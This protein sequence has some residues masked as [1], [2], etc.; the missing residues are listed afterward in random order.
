MY[1]I[2]CIKLHIFTIR[3]HEVLLS[4][5]IRYSS[6]ILIIFGFILMIIGSFNLSNADKNPERLNDQ[7]P[8]GVCCVAFPEPIIWLNPLPIVWGDPEGTQ[9]AAAPEGLNVDPGPIQAIDPLEPEAL[10][11]NYDDS[12]NR[13]AAGNLLMFIE[14]SFGALIMIASGIGAIIAGA[15]GAYKAAISL[16]FVAVGSFILRALVSLFFGTE[17]DAYR[18]GGIEFV[19]GGL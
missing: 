3:L 11:A 6:G 8:E 19:G 10:D 13:F 1:R 15:F 4:S 5:I 2:N 17:Y 18:G 9:I 14:G 7:D 12:L 16:L